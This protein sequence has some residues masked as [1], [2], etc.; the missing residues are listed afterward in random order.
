MLGRSESLSICAP[1]PEVPKISL[2]VLDTKELLDTIPDSDWKIPTKAPQNIPSWRRTDS[3]AKDSR[4]MVKRWTDALEPAIR[5]EDIARAT[6]TKGVLTVD[7]DA[8]D[9][10]E[11]L[12]DRIYFHGVDRKTYYSAALK[13]LKALVKSPTEEKDKPGEKDIRTARD[14]VNQVHQNLNNPKSA[15]LPS[16]LLI[17]LGL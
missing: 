6:Y 12:G 17:R 13:A 1:V 5:L 3:F 2:P 14:L 7:V 9:Y 10:S 16:E 8:V 4:A 15:L 11:Y